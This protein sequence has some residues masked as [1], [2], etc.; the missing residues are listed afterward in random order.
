MH[1]S[2]FVQSLGRP[3]RDG[4]SGRKP[5]V[6][7]SSRTLKAVRLG[8]YILSMSHVYDPRTLLSIRSY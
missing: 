3:E 4:P 6:G 7:K 2:I 5:A 8:P 1:I